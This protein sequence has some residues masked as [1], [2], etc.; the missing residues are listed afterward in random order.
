M[1]SI[2]MRGN[3]EIINMEPLCFCCTGMQKCLFLP[4]FHCHVEG[5]MVARESNVF[6]EAWIMYYRKALVRGATQ[7]TI[8]ESKAVANTLNS[9]ALHSF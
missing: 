1:Q 8:R 3:E 9:Y 5:E 2:A 7:D 4:F 6:S